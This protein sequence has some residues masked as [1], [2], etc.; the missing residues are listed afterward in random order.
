M[1]KEVDEYV[2]QREICGCRKIDR[3]RNMLLALEDRVTNFEE[4]LGDIKET[5]ELIKKFW[6]IK[7]FVLFVKVIN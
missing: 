7:I 5:L 6:D 1:T 4:V 2:E 3:S